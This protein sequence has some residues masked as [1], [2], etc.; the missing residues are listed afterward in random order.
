MN[1]ILKPKLKNG[2]SSFGLK[3]FLL[4]CYRL[5]VMTKL[6]TKRKLKHM[7]GDKKDMIYVFEQPES[8]SA[9]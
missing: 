2:C 7:S 8:I 4:F 3:I 9:Y 5:S 1:I 6:L